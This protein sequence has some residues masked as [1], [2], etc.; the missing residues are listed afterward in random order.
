VTRE[1]IKVSKNYAFTCF[2]LMGK[3]ALE[4]LTGPQ[5]FITATIWNITWDSVAKNKVCSGTYVSAKSVNNAINKSTVA[6]L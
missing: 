5:N 6:R 3:L 1:S 4:I 2:F